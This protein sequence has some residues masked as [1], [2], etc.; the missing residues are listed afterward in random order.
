MAERRR[1]WRHPTAR[2]CARGIARWPR[3]GQQL[4][5][6]TCTLLRVRLGGRRPELARKLLRGGGWAMAAMCAAVRAM[7][8]HRGRAVAYVLAH[9][10]RWFSPIDAPLVGASQRHCAALVAAERAAL[11][12]MQHGGGGRRP[13]TSPAALRWLISS[14]LSSGLSR[15][16]REVFGPIFDIGPNLVDFEILRFLGPKLFL[17]QYDAI[18]IVKCDFNCKI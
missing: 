14:R 11:C 18:K 8:A 7:V 12:R 16:V 9:D 1:A 5:A 3:N 4:P 10:R 15:A 2:M 6:E 17:A 13:A